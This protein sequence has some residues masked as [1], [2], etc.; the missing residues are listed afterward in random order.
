VID[1]TREPQEN[2]HAEEPEASSGSAPEEERTEGQPAAPRRRSAAIPS[3]MRGRRGRAPRRAAS[4]FLRGR[5]SIGEILGG[6][7]TTYFRGFLVFNGIALLALSPYFVLTSGVVSLV[8]DA[9]SY[10]SESVYAVTVLAITLFLLLIVF[11]L[12]QFAVGAVVHGVFRRQRGD[13]A[14]I[15]RCL[16]T[17]FGR[18]PQLAGMAFLY[19][20]LVALPFIPVF[21]L[22]LIQP[23]FASCASVVAWVVFAMIFTSFFV[24]PAAVVVERLDPW[25]SISRSIKL[26]R[27]NRWRIFCLWLVL[28]LLSWAVRQLLSVAVEASAES[29][30]PES[31]LWFAQA[32]D[33]SVTAVFAALQAVAVGLTYY[34]LKVKVEGADEDELAAVFN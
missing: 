31:F 30:E 26:T 11:E 22:G 24:A 16:S 20:V 12:T 5:I 18:L 33:W 2:E 9:T 15:G 34:H 25:A 13:R 23:M 17:A 14:G 8:P 6:T 19:G 21:L 27:G 32:V 10:A 1:E 4:R 29:F 7:F 28:G 3:S